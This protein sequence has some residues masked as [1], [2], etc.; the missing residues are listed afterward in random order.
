MSCRVQVG[1]TR[2]GASRSTETG[3]AQVTPTPR[4]W[5][6][7]HPRTMMGAAAVAVAALTA[8]SSDGTP[9]TS[10]PSLTTTSL[11]TST[12]ATTADP[13]AAA[14]AGYRAFWQAYLAAA[15]PMAPEDPR[16]A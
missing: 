6:R 8:C 11:S 5:N 13:G 7:P 12:S 15:D 4:A 3:G 14:V 1:A 10:P 2:I 16:L 9:S